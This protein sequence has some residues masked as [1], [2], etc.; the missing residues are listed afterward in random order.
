[1]RK[2][3][4]L[5]IVDDMRCPFC[6]QGNQCNNARVVQNTPKLANADVQ[7]FSPERIKT[8]DNKQQQLKPRNQ[9][10]CWCFAASIPQA[11]VDL[12]PTNSRHK[13]CICQRCANA[14]THDPRAFRR[15]YCC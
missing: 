3:G 10:D 9:L 12:V 7:M 1:M 5:S 11:L 2:V 8:A 15:K 4:D 13:Q 14:F 6:H